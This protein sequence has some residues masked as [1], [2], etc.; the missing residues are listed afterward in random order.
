MPFA[1]CLGSML[2]V[3]DLLLRR[4]SRSSHHGNHQSWRR[5]AHEAEL[6]GIIFPCIS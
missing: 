4:V 2:V 3:G 5:K 1:T 6:L